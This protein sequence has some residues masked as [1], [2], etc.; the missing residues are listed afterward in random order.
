M[1]DEGG[2]IM[3]W[4]PIVVAAFLILGFPGSPVNQGAEASGCRITTVETDTGDP[5][6]Q[7]WR[8]AIMGLDCE[9]DPLRMSAQKAFLDQR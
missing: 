6:R 4:R 1:S 8:L 9:S 3:R 7:Q 5:L 2:P